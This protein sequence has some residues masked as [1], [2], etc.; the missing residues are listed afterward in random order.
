MVQLHR[1]DDDTDVIKLLSQ[2]KSSEHNIDIG[3]VSL[4]LSECSKLPKGD[5]TKLF[6]NL[7]QLLRKLLSLWVSETT[8]SKSYSQSNDKI[9]NIVLIVSNF[10]TCNAN[11]CMNLTQTHCQDLSLSLS[12]IARQLNKSVSPFQINDSQLILYYSFC[13]KFIDFMIENYK[14]DELNIT[15]VIMILLQTLGKYS[16]LYSRSSPQTVSSNKQLLD[17]LVECLNFVFESSPLQYLVSNQLQIKTASPIATSN[18]ANKSNSNSV[19]SDQT[20][21]VLS[22]CLDAAMNVATMTSGFDTQSQ[23]Q[24]VLRSLLFTLYRKHDIDITRALDMVS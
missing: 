17:D 24:N 8:T 3:S 19:S 14:D 10:L 7:H 5:F 20:S 4:R 16:S 18:L 1:N 9:G 2:I 22:F 23:S 15:E 11:K 12:H 6:T 21:N 13:F